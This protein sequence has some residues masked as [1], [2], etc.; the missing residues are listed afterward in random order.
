MVIGGL[1]QVL[2]MFGIHQGLTP[3]ALNNM[4]TYGYEN[5]MCNMLTVPFT[6]FAVVLAVYLK[7]KRCKS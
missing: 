7:T 6:T 2:V 1:W 4:M 5:V 3:I